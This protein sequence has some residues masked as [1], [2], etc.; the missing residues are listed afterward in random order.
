KRTNGSGT[1]AAAGTAAD[2]LPHRDA[3][4]SRA[5]ALLRRRHRDASA[6]SRTAKIILAVLLLP[7][8]GGLAV[9]MHIGVTGRGEITNMQ[10]AIES[11]GVIV[12]FGGIA[13]FF[14]LCAWTLIVVHFP[15]PKRKRAAITTLLVLA[16]GAGWFVV[17]IVWDV[18]RNVMNTDTTP[19]RPVAAA[20]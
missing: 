12:V 16:A 15:P 9:A 1:R 13:A 8:I 6:L 19:S 11:M 3:V 5:H 14:L 2:R 7:A 18:V 10:N 17:A 4:R 20:E